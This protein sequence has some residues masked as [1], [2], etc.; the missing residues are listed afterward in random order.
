MTPWKETSPG[1]YSRLI[2]ENETFIKL[3]SDP[4]HPLGREHW[5]INSTATIAPQGQLTSTSLVSRLQRAWGHLRFQHPSL[6]ARVAEDNEKLVYKV[7]KSEE[8]SEWITKTFMVDEDAS[9]SAEVIPQLKP[10]SDAILIYI[11]KSN[12]LL[13]H[14]AHWRTDGI[15]VTLLLHGL[16][17]LVVKDDLSDPASLPW[18]KE[19]GRLAPAIEDAAKVPHEPNDQQ[20]ALGNHYLSTFGLAGGA[21][22]IPYV[23]EASTLP[24]GTRSVTHA[25]DTVTTNAVVEKC[26]AQSLSVTSAVHASV[27]AANWKL[28]TQ[29][30]KQEHY[31]STVRFSLRPYLPNPYS[32][33]AYAAGLYTTGWMEKVEANKTWNEHA[34][35]Y[36]QIYQKGVSR[37]YLDAHRVYASALGN[38]LRNL[39]PNLPIQSDVDISSIGVAESL[40]RR[41]Y[42]SG[43]LAIDVVAVSVGVEILTRQAVCF[44]WT[45]RDQLNLHVV[46]N[47]AYHERDQMQDFVSAVEQSL[48]TELQI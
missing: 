32:G 8:L 4:G 10:S 25:L 29:E 27:A 16:L 23:G 43:D 46:Y 40:I 33:S 11:A 18:G 47:E 2:G 28:A 35:Y 9:N 30:R 41:F 6:A 24:Q 5:A 42:G 3:V 39:P 22:G 1:T 17:Q 13:G 37:N 34:K 48:M 36:N 38:M 12:E 19:S 21:V 15:G 20:S 44:V 14:T 45:F 7:P 26:K 31:T